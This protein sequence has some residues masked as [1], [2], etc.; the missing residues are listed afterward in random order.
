MLNIS[1]YWDITIGRGVCSLLGTTIIVYLYVI[2]G[3]LIDSGPRRLKRESSKFFQEH[4]ID[5]V[6]LTHVHE[7]HSGMAAW[8][9][10]KMQVPV[11]LHEMTIPRAQK[12]GKYLFYHYLMWGNRPA[13]DPQP[14]PEC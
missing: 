7:D 4:Q 10:R 1:K 13:F 5:Q 14:F 2:D 8:L 11:Y 6:V 3:L 12:R 9:Q